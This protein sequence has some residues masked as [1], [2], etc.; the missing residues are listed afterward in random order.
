MFALHVRTSPV[1]HQERFVQAV[2]ADLV[3]GNTRSTRQVQPLWS[4]GWTC[5]YI[6]RW[7]TVPTISVTNYLSAQHFIKLYAS[8]AKLWRS[9][10]CTFSNRLKNFKYS[11]IACHDTIDED[12]SPLGWDAVSMC[13]YVP[14]HT[15]CIPEKKTS[16]LH[17]VGHLKEY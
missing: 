12:W 13:K 7:Y 9:G 10:S 14:M 2:L 5:I 16:V 11:V 4:N 8:S 15:V 1:H 17:L 3:C 6:T